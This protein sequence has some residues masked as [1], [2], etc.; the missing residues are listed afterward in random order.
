MC[1]YHFFK[2]NSFMVKCIHLV[3]KQDDNFFFFSSLILMITL[4]FGSI[5]FSVAQCPV[6]DM[7]SGSSMY[8]C[9][10]G[11]S[12]TVA[13]GGSSTGYNYQLI[14]N[15][16]N[17][18][19][20]LVPG[21]SGSTLKWTVYQPGTYTVIEYGG[22]CGGGKQMN[23]STIITDLGTP[24]NIRINAEASNYV[25]RGQNMTFNAQNGTS[26]EWFVNG[27]SVGVGSTY[28]PST[29]IAG[30]FT[31]KVQGNDACGRSQSDFVTLYVGGFPF[32]S[33]SPQ[34]QTTFCVG[35]SVVLQGQSDGYSF[36]W[37]K[38]GQSIPYASSSTYTAN[39]SG[40]YTLKARYDGANCP[41]ESAPV[42]VTVLQLPSALIS[43]EGPVQ[44][45]D[46][47]ENVL[48]TAGG[49]G[50]YTYQ[51][52]RNDTPIKNQVSKICSASLP[53]N[54]SVQVTDG[55][56][57]KNRSSATSISIVN[58]Y[59]YIKSETIQIASTSAGTD[60]NEGDMANLNEYQ[61]IEEIAYFDGL[62]REMQ[63]VKRWAS[64]GRQDIVSPVIYDE[65]GREEMK[66]LP[67]VSKDI[68][69]WYKENPI[70]T[71]PQ[72]YYTSPQA[73]FYQNGAD[74]KIVDDTMPYAKTVFEASPLN[75]VT[76]QGSAGEVWQPENHSIRFTHGLNGINEVLHFLYDEVSGSVINTSLDYYEANQLAVNKTTNENGS[77]VLE[78]VDKEAHLVCRKVQ[79]DTDSNTGKLYTET[80][81]VYDDFGNLV[82][83]IPPEAVVSLKSSLTH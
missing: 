3:L 9:G 42:S 24:P 11:N 47:Q 83:V 69:G 31:I 7:R 6:Y 49:E 25:C 23:G 74:D 19:G 56:G 38:D 20:D 72:E 70:G 65:F 30:T 76:T 17:A 22:T 26:Y 61:K 43:P 18:I 37:F 40:S 44:I 29:S 66:Y 53:G 12:A 64:P 51:W 81:Y 82:A 60:V 15:G 13:M 41:T 33:I 71:S 58:N 36:E 59:N 14:R 32:A 45:L 52:F 50:S 4:V 67:Y 75:R 35:G 63:D 54:Y 1:L 10:G 68:N 77:D 8:S 48:L 21:T 55:N 34:S 57:C 5:T 46:G 28:T 2:V 39:S 16:N 27:Q 62:G 73:I 79:Y 78:Y 80:Y